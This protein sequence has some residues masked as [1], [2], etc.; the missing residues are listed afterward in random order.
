[1]GCLALGV[2]V[3]GGFCFVV[4]SYAEVSLFGVGCWDWF[5]FEVGFYRLWRM[6]LALNF[7]H[8]GAC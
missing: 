5:D 6:M 7:G 4:N 2:W 8:D 3:S 1:M